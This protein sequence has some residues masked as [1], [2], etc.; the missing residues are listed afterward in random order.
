MAILNSP[1]SLDEDRECEDSTLVSVSLSGSKALDERR[2]HDTDLA[3][4]LVPRRPRR[5]REPLLFDPV[6]FRTG[7][8]ILAIALDFGRLHAAPA[9]RAKRR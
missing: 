3:A 9:G 7:T 6:D 1:V 8:L 4:D 5:R 2:N